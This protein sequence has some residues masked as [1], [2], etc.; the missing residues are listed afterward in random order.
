[1]KERQIT[2]SIGIEPSK[3][4]VLDEIAFQKKVSRSQLL[5]E[6]IDDYL[7]KEKKN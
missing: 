5:R 3:C 1:M 2:T 6:I 7:K 4:D